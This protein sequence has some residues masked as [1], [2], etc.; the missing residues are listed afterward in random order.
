[1]TVNHKKQ[2]NNLFFHLAINLKTG[3]IEWIN[4]CANIELKKPSN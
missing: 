2:K 3:C 4:C 1:M